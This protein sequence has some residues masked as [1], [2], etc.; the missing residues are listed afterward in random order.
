MDFKRV[1]I[2]TGNYGS[3]K[4][5][6]AINYSL[7]LVRQISH[8]LLVDLDL[9]NPYFR[10]REK[11]KILEESGIEVI[12]PRNL[13]YAE[14][15]IIPPE[16]NK[17]ILNKQY[18]GVIDVGGDQEGA[19]A[20]GSI[21]RK[22]TASEY[23]MDLVVN[24]LRKQTANVQGIVAVKERIEQRSRLVF[25]HI[26]CNVNLG[27]ESRIDDIEEGYQIIKEASRVL[28]L[29]IKFVAIR[30]DLLPLAGGLKIEEQLLPI[31]IF[32]KPPWVR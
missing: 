32:M 13:I 5:E 4:T 15:P 2:F 1:T 19:T 11:S 29:P 7:L 25:D 12:Y 3:G 24:T 30:E 14:L 18:S 10:S 16:V 31:K 23:E 21:S 28:D 26:I 9:I 8:V 22:L 6:L 17:L 27:S 20:L